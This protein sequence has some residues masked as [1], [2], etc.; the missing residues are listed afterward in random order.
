MP[1][2]IMESEV[3]ASIK[4]GVENYFNEHDEKYVAEDAVF[5]DMNSQKENEMSNGYL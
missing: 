3:S 1:H 2:G 4:E 5:N